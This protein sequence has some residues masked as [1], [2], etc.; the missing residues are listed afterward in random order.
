[1]RRDGAR[2]EPRRGPGKDAAPGPA[3]RLADLPA[4][5]LAGIPELKARLL[6][7][8]R[9]VIDLGAGD[10]GLPIPAAAAETL[11]RAAVR[12]ELQRYAFQRG[13]P[14]LRGSIAE[15]LERRYGRR[16]D[17]DQELLPLVGSKEGLAHLALA[18]L[19]PGDTVLIPDPGYAPYLGG[20][21]F[22]GA[23][24]ERVALRPE[25]DFLIPPE[26]IRDCPGRLGLV[27]LNYPNNPTGAVASSRYL[28]EIVGA[29]RERGAVLAYDNAYA[30]VAFDGYRPPSVLELDDDLEHVVEF[31]S[32][33]KSFNMTGWRLGWVCGSAELIGALARVKS[34]FDTG[35]YLAIQA[36]GAAVLRDPEGFL[37]E[38]RRL[39]RVRRDAAVSAFRGAGFS[40]SR[41]RATLYLWMPVPSGEPSIDFA[42][43]ILESEAV[44]LLPG[45][46]LGA[47]G[48]GYVRAALTTEPERLAE[49]AH[50]I[51]RRI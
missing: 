28:K 40:V 22:V 49:A 13:L 38:N 12:P 2:I 51:A 48:E 47:A 30:E 9:E 11:A 27:Y 32:F 19:D 36:A 3:R 26:R 25:E 21:F 20:G 45:A 14:E 35:P 44:V 10:T 15:F 50:R 18:V 34:F 5:P 6:A 1:V 16:I 33:S 23:R 42:R 41:P 39:L 29:T 4:Y 37:E 7:A 46:A 31:H 17:P 43:R 8:G 24:I